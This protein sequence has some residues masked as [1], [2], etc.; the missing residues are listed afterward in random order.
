MDIIKVK[1]KRGLELKGAMFDSNKS[2]TVVVMLTGICS[3]IFQNELLYTTGKLLNQNNIS[4]IIAHAHDAFSCFAH[5]DF[6]IG[7]QK[8]AGVI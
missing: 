8:H 3:N 6:S 7:K 2:D 4:C 1:T 5:T